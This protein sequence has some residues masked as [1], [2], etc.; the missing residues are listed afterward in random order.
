L[1]DGFLKIAKLLNLHIDEVA[2]IIAT[3]GKD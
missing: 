3:Y 2:N 1:E